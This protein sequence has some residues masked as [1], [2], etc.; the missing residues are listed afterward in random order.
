MCLSKP[1]KL[2]TCECE[3]QGK[4]LDE[5]E[6]Y[7]YVLAGITNTCAFKL[8]KQSLT[9]KALKALFKLKTLIYG[10]GLKAIYLFKAV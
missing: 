4:K 8:A 9:N 2:S 7:T 1:G 5:V 3:T 6:D 10:S